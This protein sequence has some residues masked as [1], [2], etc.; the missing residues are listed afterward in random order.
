MVYGIIKYVIL[1]TDCN[2][3]ATSVSGN[4]VDGCVCECKDDFEGSKCENAKNLGQ[5]APSLQI[6]MEIVFIIL[7][8]RKEVNV[9]K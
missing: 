8:Q 1:E 5:K 7:N 3:N 6:Q 4:K 2:N 9:Q